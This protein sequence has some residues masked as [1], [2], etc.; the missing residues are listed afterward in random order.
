MKLESLKLQHFRN[1]DQLDAKFSPHLNIVLGENAQGKTNLLEALYVLALT[2]SHRTTSDRA[3]IQ[4]GHDQAVLQGEVQRHQDHRRLELLINHQ[5]KRAKVDY[6]E[7][8]KLSQYIGQLHVVLFAPEDLE[9]VKGAPSSRRRFLDMEFGQVS[10]HYLYAISQYRLLLRQRNLYLRQNQTLDHVYF[11]VLTEQLIAQAAAVIWQRQH[12]LQQLMAQ[13]AQRH[14]LITQ[15]HEQLTY[16]YDTAVELTAADTVASLVDKLKT[17]FK[18]YQQRE[19]QQ[20]VTLLGPHRDDVI[21]R[22]NDQ[23]VQRFA[24]QGQQRTVALSLKLAEIDFIQAQTQ[25]YPIL[26]LD[27]VLSELDDQRQTHL[28]EAI[29]AP[30]QTFL[31]TTNLAGVAENTREKAYIVEIKN[32]QLQPQVTRGGELS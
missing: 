4:W 31:T 23:E 17:K 11:D 3:L 15:H 8:A 30:I 7:Q 32:G 24:S 1:Y 22:I 19:L 28:L 21:F 12:F 2:R 13:A 5:G 14:L 25:E 20:R 6:L 10:A 16:Q 9:L 27:D 18:H 26:L 29:Q